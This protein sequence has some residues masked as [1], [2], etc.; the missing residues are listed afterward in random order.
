MH[1]SKIAAAAPGPICFQWRAEVAVGVSA[2]TGE[3][4][5]EEATA[6]HA[7]SLA[8]QVTT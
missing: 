7:G 8:G 6:K 4:N 2:T 1:F 5:E 3:I